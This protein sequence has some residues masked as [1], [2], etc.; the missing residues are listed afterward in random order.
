MS[1]KQLSSGVKMPI[2][3]LGTWKSK[4]GK[5]ETAVLEALKV[6][7][8]HIDCAAAYGNEKE[9]GAALKEAFSTGIVKREDVFITSKLWNTFHK[10]EHVKA[11]L[12]D[13][14]A[15]FF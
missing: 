12:N 4:P 7:Y 8:R 11:A 10:P 1:F 2:L 14:L 9:V 6:G 3:G 5:V 13:S 15:N